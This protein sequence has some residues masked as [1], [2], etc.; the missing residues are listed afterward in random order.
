VHRVRVLQQLE[1][2]RVAG[3][4]VGDDPLLFLGDDAR[5]P[6]GTERHLLERLLEV[7]LRDLL[8]V[9]ARREDRGLVHDD[10]QVGAGGAWGRPTASISSM[11][12][13]HGALRFAWSK[14]SR[15]RLAPT[16]TNIST[17]SEP[18]IEK[19]GTPASPATARASIV[20]PVPGGPTSSTPRGIRAPSELNFSGYFRNSTTSVSSC[21]A[22]STPA[23]SSNVT[24]GL[25]PMNIRARLFPKLRAWLFVPWACRIM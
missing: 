20:F 5:S 14:R 3:L 19:N 4:V 17:N 10:R 6:L 15:T 11:N 9:A 22:S 8:L 1:A 12:T 21:L 2:E 16:P 13:M 23:T 24:V 25:L 18:E 7:D